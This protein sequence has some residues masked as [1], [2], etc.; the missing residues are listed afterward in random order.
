MEKGTLVHL[1]REDTDGRIVSVTDN[2]VRV[3]STDGFDYIVDADDLVV[4]DG[5]L[6][7]QMIAVS[8][9][10]TRA[11]LESKWASC[12]NRKRSVGRKPVTVDLHA[13]VLIN[14]KRGLSNHDIHRLQLQAISDQLDGMAGRHGMKIMFLHGKGDGILRKELRDEVG[15]RGRH[16]CCCDAPVENAGFQGGTVVCYV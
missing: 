9:S 11:S 4:K 6:F 1:K 8:E 16:Y 12:E 10:V 7:R 2:K 5:N 13:G 3:E 15:R 14:D